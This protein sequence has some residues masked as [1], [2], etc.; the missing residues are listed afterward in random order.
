MDWICLSDET[1][2]VDNFSET[3]AVV[4]KYLVPNLYMTKFGRKKTLLKQMFLHIATV[5]TRLY[6]VSFLRKFH[7]LTL[8]THT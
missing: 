5:T 6:F 2:F 4:L 7:S 1:V 3:Y 8:F